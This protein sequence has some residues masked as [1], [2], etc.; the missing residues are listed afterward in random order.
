MILQAD[1][2]IVR[3]E[4]TDVVPM[5]QIMLT[6]LEQNNITL[7]SATVDYQFAGIIDAKSM[8]ALALKYQEKTG[9]KLDMKKS[10][11]GDLT[12]KASNGEVITKGK[13]LA[14]FHLQGQ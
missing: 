7:G 5:E 13:V 1:H 9:K 11:I 10:Q 3:M 6:L 12:F 8:I 4:T 2:Y 14:I